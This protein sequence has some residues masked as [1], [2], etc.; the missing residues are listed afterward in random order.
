MK[1]N[2]YFNEVPRLETER[3]L[4][5]PFRREDMD[6]YLAFIHDPEVQRFLG[7]GVS[8]FSAEPHISNWLN[9]I[10][11]RLLKSKTVLTWCVERKSGSRVI[12][13]VDLGGFVKKSM[14]ELAY[15]FS[16]ESWGQGF[17]S[18]AVK[19]A[20]RFG[21]DGLK[22]HR[23]QAAVRP[24]NTASLRVLEKSGFQQ[25]G[26]LRKYYFGREFHDT[27]M[28]SAVREENLSQEGRI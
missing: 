11:G 24:E 22:L 23:I 12:G 14:A 26:L 9:N 6:A 15:Y 1:F 28:L 2:D 17:A 13:R 7:G 25:E 21:F 4:L 16:R 5:R 3:L 8:L 27:V 19:E 18:E 20:V 10:N